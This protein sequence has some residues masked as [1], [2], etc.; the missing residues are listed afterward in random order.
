MS[1]TVN[2]NQNTEQGTETKNKNNNTENKQNNN[3][4]PIN[5]AAMISKMAKK[6]IYDWIITDPYM[7]MLSYV[8]SRVMGQEDIVSVVTNIYTHLRRM[9]GQTLNMRMQTRSGSN[10]MLLCAPSGCGKTETYRAIK[11]YFADRIPL[12]AV[13]IVDVSGLTPAGFRGSEP[14]SVVAPLVGYGSEPIA[15]VF[16][17]EFDKI[18]TPSYTA[19]HS[20]MHLEVQHNILTMVEG[21]RVETARG[22]VD[23]KNILFIGAGSF[24]G[25]RKV[26][27]SNEKSEIGFQ[28]DENKKSDH[29]APVTRENIITAGGCYELIGRFSYIVNYHPLDKEIVL[30]IIDRNRELI[31][32]DFGCEL[33]LERKALNELCEQAGSKF[34]CRLLDSLMRDPVLKAY[35]DALQSDTYGDVLV[36]TLK[37]L[38]TYSYDFRDYTPE[39]MKE[40]AMEAVYNDLY[41]SATMSNIEQQLRMNFEELLTS[42]LGKNSK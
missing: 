6:Q 33:I 35:G 24:D 10:N 31:A 23:T 20:D 36:I 32:N 16:M 12:L 39:E 21:S 17:D 29:Y 13:H 3:K 38:G 42:I 30:S 1:E 41:N 34:G 9:I 11:D 26:R 14:L 22:V 8:Q 15:I 4:T 5:N 2:Q 40:P 37:D 28:K 18:C 25:F 27:E 19:D 7:E